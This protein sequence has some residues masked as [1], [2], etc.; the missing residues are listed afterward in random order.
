MKRAAIGLATILFASVAAAQEYVYIYVNYKNA[1]GTSSRHKLECTD[2]DCKAGNKK[3]VRPVRLS[4]AQRGE[5]LKALQAEMRQF[6][7][8]GDP[9]PGGNTM[10]LKI[11]YETPQKRMSIE[12]RLGVDSPE[13]VTP[14]M[15]GVLKAYL[16]LEIKKP[17][18]PAPAPGNEERAVPD[19]KM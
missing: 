16:D 4:D 3:E 17:E 14:E 2:A 12:R 15:H 7:L 10:K 5:L 18:S 19:P 11:K 1:D 13:A 8:E 6:A 9:A